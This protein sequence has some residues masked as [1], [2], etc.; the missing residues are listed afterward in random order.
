MNQSREFAWC[1]P[2]YVFSAV[3]HFSVDA[4][5]ADC[6]ARYP[7][8]ELP[9]RGC[10]TFGKPWISGPAGFVKATRVRGIWIDGDV[11]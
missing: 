1:C 7:H 11:R 4:C 8:S 6:D 5:K 10:N 9:G 2:G 3:A